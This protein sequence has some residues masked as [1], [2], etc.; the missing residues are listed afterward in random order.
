MFCGRCGHSGNEILV[1]EITQ[2][3]GDYVSVAYYGKCEEYGPIEVC[4]DDACIYL[5]AR[6]FSHTLGEISVG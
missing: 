2:V 5:H 4:D 6:E 3:S 1:D